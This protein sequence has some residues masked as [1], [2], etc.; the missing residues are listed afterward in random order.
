MK[1]IKKK[2]HTIRIHSICWLIYITYE[3]LVTASI[4]GRFSHFLYYLFFYV[5]NI[6]LFYV[7]ALYVMP[8]SFDVIRNIWRLPFLLILE[9]VLYVG[10]TIVLTEALEE[11]RVRKSPLVIN[12][13]FFLGTIWR[14]SLFI[15]FSTGYYFLVSF[16]IKRKQQ[17][18]KE[19]EVDRLQLE[20]V[21]MERNFLRSQIN[22]HLLFNTLNFIKY[23]AK[24]EPRQ[25]DDAINRLSQIMSFAMEKTASGMIPVRDELQQIENV[26]QLNRLR[27]GE[28]LKVDFHADVRDEKALIIPVIMLTLVEN[29]FKH[30]DLL[31]TTVPASIRLKATQNELKFSTSNMIARGT[32]TS[33]RSGSGLANTQTRL[34]HNYGDKAHFEFGS[35]GNVFWT[36]LHLSFDQ[37]IPIIA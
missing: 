24:R 20:L 9:I 11:L 15:L 16:L 5:L 26:I 18:E 19:L 10:A 14:G 36:W 21:T 6:G 29:V 25:A 2:S 13:R 35:D 8:R 32:I 22:P 3:V 1:T 23:A 17:L 27:F 12:N 34:Q 37:P 7:H 28:K 4:S 31:V 33:K 30:G